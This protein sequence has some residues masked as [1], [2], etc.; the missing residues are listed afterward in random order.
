MQIQVFKDENIIGKV[1][2]NM[3]VAQVTAK[4]DSVLGLATGSSPLTTYAHLIECKNAGL[5]DFS[6][7][8]TFNLD[9]YVGLSADHPCSYDYFMRQNLFDAIGLKKEQSLIPS[10][11]ASD[12]DAECNNYETAIEN[13]GGIDLQILGIGHNGHIAFNEPNTC[14]SSKTNVVDL[15]ESTILANQ[16]F[17]DSA[18]DVPKKAI[19]TGI[20]TIFRAKNIVLIA[21]GSG[22]ADAVRAMINGPITPECPASILQ[23]HP[24][25]T[26]LVDEAAAARL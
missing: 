17:F 23:L 19:T 14:F 24:S 12:F 21:T 25:V 26:V 4:A 13:A 8:K 10:G 11:V 16:R 6:G 9:E 18:D 22:K 3:I 1:A 5:V 7:I 20:G 15:T 2:G